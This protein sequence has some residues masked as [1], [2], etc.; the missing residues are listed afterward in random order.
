M[1]DHTTKT[2]IPWELYR[3]WYAL[4]LELDI[5]EVW[6]VY[7]MDGGIESGSYPGLLVKESQYLLYGFHILSTSCDTECCW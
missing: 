2:D 5:A 4:V 7:I 1:K 3:R 6:D